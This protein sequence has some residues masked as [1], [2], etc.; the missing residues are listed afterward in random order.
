MCSVKPITKIQHGLHHP[1]MKKKNQI[2]KQKHFKNI[3]QSIMHPASHGNTSLVNSE[4]WIFAFFESAICYLL[5]I[6]TKTL[7]HDIISC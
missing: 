6:K 4:L 3:V 1:K 2:K 7:E 5:F